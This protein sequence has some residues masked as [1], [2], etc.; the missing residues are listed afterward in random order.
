MKTARSL[1]S[2]NRVS[3]VT[4]LDGMLE[5]L[6]QEGSKSLKVRMKIESRID[7]ENHCPCFRARRDGIICAHALAAGL[8]YLEPSENKLEENSTTKRP[9]KETAPVLS[10]K[11]PTIVETAS[12]EAV[13]ASLYLIL[14]PNFIPSWD[15]GR[16]SV[17]IEIEIN[18]ER[19]LLKAV[20]NKRPLFLFP[21]DVA[22]YRALQ[23]ISPET[24]PGM[25]TIGQEDFIKILNAVPGHPGITFGKREQAQIS[26][27][28]LRLELQKAGANTFSIKWPSDA[29]PLIS[30]RGTWALL[31]GETFHPV[32]P[33]LASKYH[34]VLIGGYQYESG[35]IEGDLNVFEKFFSFDLLNIIRE[36]PQVRLDLEGSINH[37][38]A[39]LSFEYPGSGEDDT[40]IRLGDSRVERA[41]NNALSQWGF[42]QKGEHAGKFVLKDHDEILRFFAHGFPR[43]Q[44]K[45]WKITTNERF[46]HALQK[47]EP[48][49]GEMEFRSGSGQNWFGLEVEFATASG[50]SISRQEIQRILQMGQNSKKLAHGKIAV[51]D[52]D[53]LDEFSAVLTDC[54]PDQVQPGTY[55]INSAHAEYLRDSAADFGFATKGVLPLDRGDGSI[56][57]GDLP[58]D[59]SSILR[60][61][62]KTGIEWM[63]RLAAQGKGG[64]LADDMGLGKT[65]QT[66][67]FIQSVGGLAFVVC[68]SSLVYNWIAEVEKFVPD[69]KAIAME[70][71]NRAS[72]L[73]ENADVDIIVTSYALLRRDEGLYRDCEITTIILDEAQNIKNPEAK[74]SKA[75]HR[76]SAKHRFALTGTPIENS[77]HDLW[78][79]MNFACPGYLGS[80]K[81]F[82]E[83]FEK[84]LT[85]SGDSSS[86]Q[87]RLVRRLRPVI[88]RRLKSEVA[89]DLPEKIQQVIYC[90][91]NPTQQEVYQ[92]ILQESREIILDAEGGRKRMLALTA[93]LRLRQTCCDIRLL[94]LQEIDPENASVKSDILEEILN[95]AIEGG[96]RVLVF[97]QFVEML[98]ILVPVLAEKG[99]NFCYLDGKTKKRGEVVAKFQ[100]N[101]DIPVFLISLKAGGVGLNLTGADTVIH[102]DPWW[103]PA[104]EAQA[105]DRAHRIGQTRMVNSYK[106]IARNT[107][108]E[109]I[110]ALQ[111]RKRSLTENLLDGGAGIDLGDSGL[112][113]DELM[114]F[115]E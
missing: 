78:S 49:V 67:A 1:H 2:M 57:F 34:K 45:G 87:R 99:I 101:D 4:Y 109:K 5:G 86:V 68:P 75:A 91:L 46:E 54:E 30:N 114:S 52:T 100:E 35:E 55:Q 59:L 88:L 79:I 21:H 43:F 61:Y 70:G 76:L 80:R 73:R 89:S 50:D 63:Q 42:F 96:H 39:R 28:S 106:L 51:L 97:S 92:K 72:H 22:L 18:G 15:K 40:V 36:T 103:N 112:S 104:V 25:L 98:Q 27:Q 102:I 33:G 71:P 6:V 64:I 62:Q 93:L 82:S 48:V 31:G 11:W 26:Y 60:P 19:K 108:E 17:G 53:L 111:N 115:F 95:E 110:L 14:S 83:R 10:E 113:E 37:L 41:A 58:A 16:I 85:G 44:Q 38:D 81:D 12:D 77:V 66:L 8:E 107:V 84:P 47:V 3:D 7:M 56:E 90:D 69:L 29:Q 74:V 65:L 23:I 105:T 94:G 13:V 20:G 24:V 9:P 32:A